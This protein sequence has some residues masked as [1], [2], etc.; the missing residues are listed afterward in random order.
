MSCGCKAVTWHAVTLHYSFC[1]VC[2]LH[3]LT[4]IE[5]LLCTVHNT[6]LFSVMYGNVFHSFINSS[7]NFM[8]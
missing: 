5:H 2:L 8:R 1:W 6:Y 7:S 3:N 4:L